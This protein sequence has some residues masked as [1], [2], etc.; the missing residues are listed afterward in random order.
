MSLKGLCVKGL[1]GGET[2]KW[3]LVG[4]LYVI[5]GVPLRGIV[6][7]QLPRLSLPLSISISISLFLWQFFEIGSHYVSQTGLK[8]KILLP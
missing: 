5:G 4:G 7:L 8:L 6:R 1:G 3:G 2:K